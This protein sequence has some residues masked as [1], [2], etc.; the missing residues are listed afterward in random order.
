MKTVIESLAS[1]AISPRD[2]RPNGPLTEPRSFGV[3]K[4]PASVSGTRRFRL[5]NHPV[6]YQ[7]L[8]REF[9]SCKLLY[10]FKERTDAVSMASALNG[11]N[12]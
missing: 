10:L 4:L 2:V 3:Y 11:P 5:G 9:G 6:R 1:R 12:P 8:E 7:E